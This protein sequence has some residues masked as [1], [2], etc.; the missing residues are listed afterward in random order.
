MA[1]KLIDVTKGE[2]AIPRAVGPVDAPAPIVSTGKQRGLQQLGLDIQG[3][4]QELILAEERVRSKG[5]AVERARAYSQYAERASGELRRLETEDDFSKPEAMQ[6]YGEF[7][8]ENMREIIDN[9]AGSDNSRARLIT[10]L[11]TLRFGYANDAAAKSAVAQEQLVGRVVGGIIKDYSARAYEAPDTL[12]TL[13]EDFDRDLDDAAPAL[14]P[15]QEEIFRQHGRSAITQNII[16]SYLSRQAYGEAERV[17]NIPGVSNVLSPEAHA[18]IRNSIHSGRMKLRDERMKGILAGRETLDKAATILNIDPSQLTKEQREKLAGLST[19]E[20]FENIRRFSLDIINQ[21]TEAYAQG[22]LTPEEEG[23]FENAITSYMQPYQRIDPDTQQVVVETPKISRRVADALRARGWN[24]SEDMISPVFRGVQFPV[25]T[26]ET[27][28]MT[29]DPLGGRTILEIS[30]LITGPVPTGAEA[31]GQTPI[32]GTFINPKQFTQARNFVPI[33]QR[34]LVT[35]LQNSPKYAEGERNQI[36]AEVQIE[37]RFWDNQQAFIN[38]L[39][40]MDDA[41]SVYQHA[42]AEDLHKADIG[43]ERRRWAADKFNAITRF[44]RQ[45][46]IPPRLP[47]SP[48]SQRV[49]LE[50]MEDGALFVAPD[51][52]I[53][54]VDRTILMSPEKEK[55]IKGG[56]SK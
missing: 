7:L 45:L 47:A 23:R 33:V 56:R 13:F 36:Q 3:A 4:S 18:N 17:L 14:T 6:A 9:H 12:A 32:I 1:T 48:E 15:T 42:A 49:F 24:I 34:Q 44:R 37:G 19:E 41:L 43:A 8:R 30:G 22:L 28:A 27:A 53:R 2:R 39:I 51:G 55:P 21:H 25:G 26:S 35:A 54:R 38:R 40:A 20:K 11:E 5:D 29:E 16:E 31:L 10:K 50:R 46:G 52:T